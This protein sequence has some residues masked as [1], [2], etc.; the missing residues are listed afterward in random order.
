[1]QRDLGGLASEDPGLG[2]RNCICELVSKTVGPTAEEEDFLLSVV[3]DI[4][5]M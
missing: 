4:A 5:A 1:M 3:L 2:V